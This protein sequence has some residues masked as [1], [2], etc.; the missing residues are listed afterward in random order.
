MA[1]NTCPARSA[2]TSIVGSGW[3]ATAVEPVCAE[4]PCYEKINDPQ[5][6]ARYTREVMGGQNDVPRL[7]AEFCLAPERY[8]CMQHD[9]S[10]ERVYAACVKLLAET[11]P[12]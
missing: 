7:F 6:V 5:V 1:T 3:R 9:N 8:R 11:L 12:A 10:V 2:S 4:A